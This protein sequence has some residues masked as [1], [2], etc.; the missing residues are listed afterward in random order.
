MLPNI[1]PFIWI[2]AVVIIA[3]IVLGLLRSPAG[4][5]LSQNKSPVLF[6][7][8]L[9]P[10]RQQNKWGYMNS[11]SKVV[12]APVFEDADDFYEELAAVSMTRQDN[13][14]PL[15]GYINTVG[16]LKVD[17]RYEKAGRFS[18]GL[19]AVVRNRKY[20]FIDATGQQVVPLIYEE[21]SSF[22]EGLAVVK[23]DGKNGFID[24][25][26]NMVIQ[27]QFVRACWVSDFKEGLSPVYVEQ[28]DQGGYIDS[29]GNFIIPPAY[30]YA[31][32]FS[33]GLA[34][35]KPAGNPAY[36]YIDH[37]GTWVI[38]PKYELSLPFTEGVASVKIRRPDGSQVF[39]IIDKK[40]NKISGD[41]DYAFVGIFREGL[42]GVE[43]H[44][45]RWGFIDKTGK[46]IIK[47]V[48]AGLTLFR[49]GLC[50][51]QTGSLFKGLKTAYIDKKGNVIWEE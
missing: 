34:L 39:N 18:E 14:A 31:G 51:V 37:K 19:A 8:A 33:E 29:T 2:A 46:E 11:D 16:K 24:K 41:L 25:H 13:N 28:N 20:G 47:P 30:D 27:P 15:F 23:K 7:G 50:R 26:G 43:T 4:N 42:A 48:Y 9:Y 5:R 6:Q 35:V 10:V 38:Q 17:Y 49:N 40:G 45:L 12:I 22:S 3:F 21:V 32:P 36:G 1:K 44:D